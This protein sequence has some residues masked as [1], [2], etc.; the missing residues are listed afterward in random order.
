MALAHSTEGST[1]QR[2]THGGICTSSTIFRLLAFQTP[3]LGELQCWAQQ[4]RES[5]RTYAVVVGLGLLVDADPVEE[6]EGEGDDEDEEHDECPA[7][8]HERRKN[9]ASLLAVETSVF[10]HV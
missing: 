4:T 7:T 8:Q 9:P 5:V 3:V 1:Y 6:P 2:V 10:T